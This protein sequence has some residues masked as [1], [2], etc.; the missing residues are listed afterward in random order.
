MSETKR[1]PI[2]IVDDLVNELNHEHEL[3][4]LILSKQATVELALRQAMLVL[5]GTLA[6]EL[7]SQ[8][9][10]KQRNEM[11]AFGQW[12]LALPRDTSLEDVSDDESFI[13]MATLHKRN[14]NMSFRQRWQDIDSYTSISLV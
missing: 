13:A 3:R 9:S 4:G 14:K 1:T 6:K 8:W 2:R 12:C 5:D 10:A 7:A 11:L